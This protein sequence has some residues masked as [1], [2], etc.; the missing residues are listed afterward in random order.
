MNK[1]VEDQVKE[2]EIFRTQDVCEDCPYKGCDDIC[3]SCN[4][5]DE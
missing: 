5:E 1:S 3:E 2:L 4:M